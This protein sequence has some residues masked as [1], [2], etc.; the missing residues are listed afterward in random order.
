MVCT[1][2]PPGY[3]AR[4]Q[5]QSH[6]V[7]P[8]CFSVSAGD[9]RVLLTKWVGTA[10]QETSRRLKDTLIRSFVKRG[11]ALPISGS[12]DGE[13]DGLSKYRMGE[14]ADVEEG[15]LNSML[16]VHDKHIRFVV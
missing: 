6:L 4:V 7:R 11:I 14:S 8:L 9:W 1:G 16:L 2:P 10:W 5:L 13:I 12:R 3:Q 15:K